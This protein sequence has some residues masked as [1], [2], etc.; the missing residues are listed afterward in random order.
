WRSGFGTFKCLFF[1]INTGNAS[2]FR[3]GLNIIEPSND[4]A[5]MILGIAL[6]LKAIEVLIN[7][8]L[9]LKNIAKNGLILIILLTF[10]F[11]YLKNF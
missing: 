4:S 2:I 8:H 7:W 9:G 11:V 10:V 3:I 1:G 5:L 6:S